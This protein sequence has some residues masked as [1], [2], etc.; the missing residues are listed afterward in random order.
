MQIRNVS[1][2]LSTTQIPISAK[3]REGQRQLITISNT[4]TG[5]QVITLSLF[6]QAVAGAGVVLNPNESWSESIDSS[7]IPSNEIWYAVSSAA[8]GKIALHERLTDEKGR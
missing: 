7:F 1:I 2:T 3:V 6:V 4:S 5:G 8:G